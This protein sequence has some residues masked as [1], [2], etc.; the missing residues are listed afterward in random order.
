MAGSGPDARVS[1]LE[2]L[3]AERGRNLMRAAVAKTYLPIRRISGTTV[4]DLTWLAP[5]APNLALLKLTI[6]PGFQPAPYN[7]PISWILKH[8][9][10][11]NG[12][13]H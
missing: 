3:L 7:H 13:G 12:S 11:Y 1:E 6:P 9:P 10:R 8:D 4:D 5:T 2:R